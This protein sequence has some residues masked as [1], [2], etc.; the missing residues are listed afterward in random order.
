MLVG[1]REDGELL[2]IAEET[3]AGFCLN[4]LEIT[5]GRKIESTLRS[6][7]NDKAWLALGASERVT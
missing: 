5:L 1:L 2:N 6:N 3:Q 4:V 7:A